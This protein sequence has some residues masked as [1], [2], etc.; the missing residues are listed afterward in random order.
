MDEKCSYDDD[1]TFQQ[2]AE[3]DLSNSFK[4]TLAE[5]GLEESKLTCPWLKVNP[6]ALSLDSDDDVSIIWCIPVLLVVFLVFYIYLFV[7]ELF[8]CSLT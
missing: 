3:E 8:Y 6:P 1:K 2:P 4:I 7:L 5:S